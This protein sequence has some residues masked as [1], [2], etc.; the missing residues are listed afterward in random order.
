MNYELTTMNQQI[1]TIHQESNAR[2]YIE[3]NKIL[4][5]SI[6]NAFLPSFRESTR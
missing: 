1:T 3:A 5:N 2:K 4:K 6:Y